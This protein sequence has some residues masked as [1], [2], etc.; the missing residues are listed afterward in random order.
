MGH[1]KGPSAESRVVSD[2]V[3]VTNLKE[4]RYCNKKMS[5]AIYSV[6]FKITFS[7][8]IKNHSCIVELIATK[9][10]SAVGTAQFPTPIFDIGIDADVISYLG[11][12]RT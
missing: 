7:K 4:I 12:L 1:Q 11:M 5:C 8:M 10:S 3:G 6:G 9:Q 2:N